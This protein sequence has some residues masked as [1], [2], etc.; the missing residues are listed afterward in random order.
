[1]LNKPYCHSANNLI[2]YLFRKKIIVCV[3]FGNLK[4]ISSFFIINFDLG[5]INAVKFAEKF[6]HKRID[7]AES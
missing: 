5:Y 7:L 6:S 4:D 1:M 2:L 3:L